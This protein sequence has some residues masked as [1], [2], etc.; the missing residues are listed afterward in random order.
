MALVV[1]DRVQETTATT[2][3]GPI[4]LAGAVAGFQ[5]FAVI[6]DGNT[7]Y[8]ALVNGSNWEVGVGTYST[9]G[10]SLARTTILTNSLGTTVA[11][12]LVGSSNVFVTYPA[13]KSVN[14]DETGNVSPLGTITSGVWNG[15]TIPVAYGGTGVTASSGA[16]SVV[17]R[18]A[19]G[20]VTGVNNAI[21]GITFTTAS[22]GVTT[23]VASS[24]QVQALVG[25]A[26]HT[27][28]LPDATTL[29]Q[30][31]FYTFSNASSGTL[32]VQNSAG[33]VIETIEQGGAAQALCTSTATIAGTW[34]FRVFAASNV[35]WGNANLDY[36]GTITSATWQGVPVASN[37]GG[38]GLTTF[39][40]ANNALYST[41]ASTLTAGTLPILAGGTGATTN[42][43]A[44]TNLGATTLGSNL[45]TI[46]NPSAVTF[47]RFNADNTVSS[48]NAV[49]FRTA[50]GAGTSS[51][52]GTVTSVSG[53]GTAS[54]LT[55]SGTVTTS[56]NL[57]LSGTVNSLA[58]GT[59][60]ISISGNAATA[61]TASAVPWSGITGRPSNI[62]FY[63]GFTLNADTMTTNS[64]GFTYSV[65]APHTGPIARFSAGGSYDLEINA[66]YNNTNISYRARNG[67]SGVWQGW[68]AF[69]TAAN[70]GSY[71]LPLSGGTM[72]GTITNSAASLVIGT[73]GGLQRGYLYNDT[74]GFGLLTNGGS[75][76]L[77]VNYGTNTVRAEGDVVA[78][79]RVSSSAW[80]TTAR[81]YSSEW[82]E[83]PN[84]SGLYS[85]LNGAH[86]YPNNLSY[87][88]WRIEG[89]RNG[90]GGIEF[91]NATTSL[92]MNYNAYGFHRND[93]GWRFYNE[94][95]S[96]YFPGV[97]QAG[98]SDKRLKEN[99]R[100]MTTEALD[101]VNQ[102]QTYRFN[103]NAKVKEM[104]LPIEIGAE[105]VGCV[106]QEVQEIFPDAVAINKSA[107]KTNPD[108]S[109]IETDYLTINY[110]KLTPLLIQSVNELTKQIKELQFEIAVLK[111]QK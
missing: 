107:N 2:G 26:N 11:I 95:G 43:A 72:T 16:N 5:S 42:T 52:T 102:L 46:T 86:F 20:N 23:L 13:G 14:L 65:N 80:S 40:G 4:T 22:A 83:L 24:T 105:E 104:G 103:W 61:T 93:L 109:Q 96:G 81:N 21:V 49:D 70:F 35:T 101:I 30:G 17:L 29:L 47:P 92:M 36:S 88:P 108:G 41:G 50:I 78:V 58:A 111:G 51:T 94:N 68:N 19:N 44:R 62:M 66:G 75:W 31:I 45:F 110:N 6:G 9:T 48:L 56:G 69:L 91:A 100:P 82:I 38:T 59:Y 64:T 85:P 3:T 106:A 53:T 84:H 39:V 34:G 71:A 57:T 37:H 76:A 60:G 98:W 8:Y 27:F 74:A 1:F 55:L 25:S 79:G 7:T 32:T 28:R 99:F 89:T 73:F 54:G 97:V 90:W 10:P 87:G 12:S 63:E 77:R 67:D 15:T 18:D 33:T